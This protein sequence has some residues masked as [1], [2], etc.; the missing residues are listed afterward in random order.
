MPS[1][2]EEYLEFLLTKQAAHNQILA[3]AQLVAAGGVEGIKFAADLQPEL[4]LEVI[5]SLSAL[6]E[7]EWEA[8]LAFVED[9]FEIMDKILPST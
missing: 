3:G 5:A 2:K 9:H 1:P 6:V 8:H 7:M 4:I